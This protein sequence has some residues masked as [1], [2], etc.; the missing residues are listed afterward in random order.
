M[1]HKEFGSWL[2]ATLGCK[3]QK[4][5]VDAGFTCPN[6]D[7]TVGWGGCTFCDNR[8]FSPAYCRQAG[9]VTEQLEAGKRF[10]A[11]KYPTLKY[12]AYFQ[13]YTGTHAPLNRLRALYQEALA[14]PD[15]VGLVIGTRPDCMPDPL[16]DYLEELHQRT[17]V[18]VE[19]GVES[20]SDDTLRR[21]HRGHTFQQAQDAI[22]RTAA[23]GLPVGAHM[24]LGFPWESHADLMRQADLMATL[25]LT[26][27]KLHQLQVIRGTALARD[28]E[29]APWPMPT[30]QDYVNLVLDYVSH[31][32]RTLVLERFVSQSPPEYVI[33]PHWGLKNHEF[34]ALVKAAMR[35]REEQGGEKQAGATSLYT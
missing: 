27:L 26:T 25:P 23:R 15:V 35:E 17:F 6:R 13:A 7:G 4:L 34:A 31:L 8:T 9:T 29:A 21:V 22:R 16:L 18:L 20:A 33:A 2:Q 19:Y 10:F 5:S 30:A 32:P 3:A 11:H 12:L 1:E 24:I 14:V 28:Y